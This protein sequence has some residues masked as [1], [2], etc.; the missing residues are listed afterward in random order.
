MR[1]LTMIVFLPRNSAK[2][3]LFIPYASTKYDDYTKKV[4]DAV[5]S[6]NYQVEGIAHTA[7]FIN[8]TQFKLYFQFSGIHTYENREIDAVKAAEAIFIGGGNTFLLLKTLYEKNLI[9]AIRSR[10]LED[11][12]PYMGSSAGTNVATINIRTTNDMP[13]VFP[14]R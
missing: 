5:S 4:K 6:W 3:I 10:V 9:E 11:G 8:Q 1:T 7:N 12:I 2:K 13:I 14:P